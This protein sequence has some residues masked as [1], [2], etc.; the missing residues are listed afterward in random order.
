MPS[1]TYLL[2]D[3]ESFAY[4]SVSKL[5]DRMEFELGQM[6]EYI[7]KYV[8]SRTNIG[9][10]TYAKNYRKEWYF[11][12]TEAKNYGVVTHIVGEDCDIDEII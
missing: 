8:I 7:K 4:D 6:E 2:H 10:K 3:G 12:P 11:Y 9:E 1:S 5:K